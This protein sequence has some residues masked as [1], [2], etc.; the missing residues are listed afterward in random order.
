MAYQ[1]DK[2]FFLRIISL[3]LGKERLMQEALDYFLLDVFTDTPYGGNPLAVF[4]QSAGLT[5]AQM[6]KITKELNLSET[7]FLG[8]AQ[9]E[10]ADLAMRIFTPG[11]ELPTAGHPTIGTA[12][13]LLASQLIKPK[14]HSKL[15]LEQ[16][17]GNIN[18][19]FKKEGD[20]ITELLMEQPLPTFEETFRDKDLVASLLGIHAEDIYENY[21]SRIVNCG[22][23]FL[24]IPV[25]H[26]ET[27]KKIHLNTD[28]Y[29]D[30]LDEI[31]ITGILPFT[32]ETQE[33][34]NIAHSR[35][36]A[37][38]LGISEDPATGSAHGPLAAY[39]YNY[40]LA[41][42]S[43]LKQC[44]QGFEMGRPSYINIQIIA[45]EGKIEKVLIG[46]K[47]VIMGKGTLYHSA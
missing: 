11:K 34:G 13:L 24:I 10:E 19:Q 40:Q 20:T 6:L 31:D 35:M 14:Q 1:V 33:T 23:P 32:L 4:T 7:V 17:I 16:T 2:P 12:F 44:E 45:T 9:S 29:K 47:S 46:G 21:P 5:A 25:K 37:P 3:F 36:F 43:T 30:I 18:I 8:E 38:Q 42:I 28:L 22:N 39:L 15:V 26:L 41:D 27:I